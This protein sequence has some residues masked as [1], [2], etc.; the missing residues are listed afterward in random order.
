MG[1]PMSI[2][3]IIISVIVLFILHLNHTIDA[4]KFV[5]DTE[6]YLRFLMEDDYEF[7]LRIRYGDDI[8]VNKLFSKRVQTAIITVGI[9]FLLFISNLNFLNIMIIVIIAFAMFKLPYI[10]LKRFYQANLYQINLMLPYYLKSLEIL[11]QHYTVPVALARSIDTAPEIFKSG[12]R[13]LVEK[14][15]SGDSSVDPYMDFAKEYPVR[16]S[17][18]MMRLLYRLGLGSQENK[19]EQLMMFSKT[20]SQLQNK[21]REQ[22]Y[23]DRLEKM[24]KKTMMMLCCT[25]GG[26]IFLLLLSMTQMMGI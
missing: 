9:L 4:K 19:Q 22:K 16:D 8:D 11:V 10:N 2:M 5:Q 26:I 24:E 7:L 23:K 15:N 13:E 14:V 17:M 3:F 25:G 6:P 21:A 18:R 20:V 1:I 12:L